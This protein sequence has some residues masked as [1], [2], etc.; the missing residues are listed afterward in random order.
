[1]LH[2]QK[3]VASAARDARRQLARLARPT[4]GFDARRYFRDSG[5]LGFYN[6]GAPRVRAM[7]RTIAREH[8]AAWSVADAAAFAGL[9]MADRHLEVKGLGIEVLGRYRKSFTPPLLRTCK[10]WLATNL[11]A[12]WATTDALCGLVIG[13]LLLREPRL[14]AEVAGWCHHRNMWVRRASAVALIP[15]VRH[16]HA[17]DDAY[18]VAAALQSDRADL[19]QKAAGWMLREAGK[20]DAARLARYLLAAGPKTPRTTLRYA[21]ERFAPAKRKTL[22][23]ATRSAP[24]HHGSGR[25]RPALRKNRV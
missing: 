10:R 20:A 19:V 24:G 1:M 14:A 25:G 3:A 12:N 13:P 9:L 2:P 8:R 23:A 6:V 22:L 5:N 18:R 15:S 21:I 4:A 11:A 17:L 16:G 7:A